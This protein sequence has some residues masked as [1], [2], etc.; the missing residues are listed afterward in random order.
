LDRFNK[1]ISLVGKLAHFTH[2]SDYW[3]V[4]AVKND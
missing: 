1:A 2:D 3:R 4:F